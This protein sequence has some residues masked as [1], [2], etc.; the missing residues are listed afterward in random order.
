MTVDIFFAKCANISKPMALPSHTDVANALDTYQYTPH[1]NLLRLFLIFSQ[2]FCIIFEIIF[3]LVAILVGLYTPIPTGPEILLFTLVV[4][5]VIQIINCCLLACIDLESRKRN[6]LM[7]HSNLNNAQNASPLS[8]LFNHIGFKRLR[9]IRTCYL[10]F[11]FIFTTMALN[12]SRLM[13]ADFYTEYRRI[14]RIQ[15]T[16][17]NDIPV[18]TSLYSYTSFSGGR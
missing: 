2:F 5:F 14:T 16:R 6:S 1:R 15:N 13:A 11:F 12:T 8:S 18:W 4:P 17:V 7:H 3:Y 10:A 9:V